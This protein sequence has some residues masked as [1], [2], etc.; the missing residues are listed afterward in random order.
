MNEEYAEYRCS[1][2]KKSIK[3]E[4]IA[5]KSCAKLFF[6]PGCV[7]KPKIYDK[8]RELVSC[9]GPFEKFI[10]SDGDKAD[11]N[12]AVAAAGKATAPAKMSPAPSSGNKVAAASGT[13]NIDRQIDWFVKTVKELKDKAACK[14]EIKSIIKEI[15]REEMGG[16]KQE[17]KELRKMLT[18]GAYGPSG[19]AT[20]KYSDMIKERKEKNIL[21]MKPKV[22]ESEVTKKK[23][24]DKINITKMKI[25]IT[26]LRKGGKG[27][28][29]LGCETE[30]EK[31]KLKATVQAA[32]GEEVKVSEPQMRKPK[33]KIINV[34]GEEMKIEDDELIDTIKKQNRIGEESCMHL[35]KKILRGKN[36]NTEQGS[37]IIEVD[38]STHNSLINKE[39]I[40]L[41]WRKCPIFNYISVRCFKCWGYYHIAKNCTRQETCYKCAGNHKANECTTAKKRCVNCT[42]KNQTYNLKIN[43]E[44]E[45]LD[46]ECPTFKK[47]LEEEK[48]RA[49]WEDAK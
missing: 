26:K 39:K 37:V 42:Y 41:G 48:K 30:E 47:V 33:I 17:I 2:C 1:A 27:T 21:I 20:R 13:G 8:N 36:K 44:H 31:D 25:G 49:G 12:K 18:Q 11:I 6:H 3:T 34:G 10:I 38:E 15:V 24:K 22:Q 4:V 28:V 14:K 7:S 9:P 19:G 23:I 43:V 16:I 35:V 29:I 5:C 32:M 46:S 45:A 40:N